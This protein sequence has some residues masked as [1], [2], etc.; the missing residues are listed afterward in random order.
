[1]EEVG[2]DTP[3]PI[4]QAQYE[5]KRMERGMEGAYKITEESVHRMKVSL[6]FQ[7]EVLERNVTMYT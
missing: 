7:R 3:T 4:P 2:G 6:L 1:M 5:S